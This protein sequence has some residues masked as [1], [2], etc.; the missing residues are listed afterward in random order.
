MKKPLLTQQSMLKFMKFSILQSVIALIFTSLS[1]ALDS[2]GQEVLNQ[3]V[4]ITCKE[5]KLASV[6]SIIEE[7]AKVKFVF[8]SKLIKSSRIASLNV[9]QEKLATVLSTLLSPMQ[10]GYQVNGNKIILNRQAESKSDIFAKGVAENTIIDPITGKVSSKNGEVIPGA[11]VI[12]KGTKRG[13]TTD[14]I[15]SFTINADKGET[16]QV[17]FIG[18]ETKELI[19]GTDDLQ[20]IVLSESTSTLAEVAVVGSRSSSARTNTDSPVPVDIISPKELKGF[21]QVD[22]GQILNYVAPSFSSNRQTVAD[23]T[24]HIDP[25][26][27]RGLG[28]DQVLVLVNGK[29]RHTT[30]LLNINGT[31][32]RGS[33]GT[34][35]NVIPV[36]AIERIEVLRDGAAA[37]YGSDA[38]AGVINV[39]LKKNYDGFAA[40]LTSGTNVTNMKWNTPNIGGGQEAKNLKI[41]DGEVLQF[42]LSKG[43]KIGNGGHVVVSGQ[44]NSHGTTNRSGYDNAPTIYLGSAGGFPG[45]PAGGDPATFRNKI[46]A[47]DASIVSQRNYNRRNM[48]FGNSSS[49]NLGMYVNG[50]IP[51]G[52][53]AEFYFSGGLTHR[54]GTGYGN[55]RVPVSRSQQ[56]LKSDGSLFYAD[57]FLPAIQSTIED[58][59]LQFGYKTK[60]GE[61]N[62][63]LA[64]TFGRNTFNFTVNN[65]GNA[66]LANND[67]QQTKFD[68]GTLKFDQNTT[69]LDFSRLYEKVGAIS[70]LNI[71]F[72][73][74]FRR[75]HYQIEAGETASY[76]GVVK[77][78]PTAPLSIGGAAPGT[79]VA[80]PGSQVFPGFQPSNAVNKART[81]LGLYGDFEGEIFDR[82]LL[83]LAGRY[84]NY[85]DFGSNFSGKISGRLKLIEGL[86]LRGSV[87]TGFRAPSLHQRYFSNISTQFVSGL[88][89]NTLTVNND[90]PIARKVIGVD[91]LRPETSL[92]FTTGVTARIAKT[93]TITVD[94]YQIAIKDRVVYSGAFSR[95]LLGF[96]ATDYVGVNNVNFFANAA[97]TR[98][99]GV[100]IV[101]NSKNKVANGGLNVTIAMN[102]NK[103]KVTEIN[104]TAL[105]D[106]PEKNV[107]TTNPGNWFKN[108]LF[109]RQQI[110]RIE[111]WQPNSKINLSA[112]YSVGKFDFSLRTVR[113]GQAQYVHN[114]YTEAKKPD[115]I[116]WNTSND[117]AGKA[118]PLFSYNSDGS[119]KIDQVFNPVWI[120]DLAVSYKI[121]KALN[122]TFGANNLF[123]VYPDQIF[124][125]PRN[126]NGSVDY[127]SGRDASNRGRLLFQ[128]NQGGYNGRYIFGRLNFNF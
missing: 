45:T 53:K 55:N 33:V 128:P 18:Y 117:I 30:A 100:D 89:S 76:S 29:R 106:S 91:A 1:F 57:G 83:G 71:A 16:L 125:D 35:M 79:T 63:D 6:L 51:I 112:V 67:N 62:M 77:S 121:T 5:Q 81:N 94:A 52:T 88:P 108:L 59:S 39:V 115:G 3:A 38:I 34:D 25:A 32:G 90:D 98:T 102:F 107:V 48:L 74:E 113:F 41:T 120:T 99:Q 36:A 28:P 111:V 114:A 58:Q 61:W 92:S 9:H 75:D 101:I 86:A 56:P 84:E 122:L 70:G 103:N 2:K 93:T 85:S 15:G 46:I 119:A 23:G 65:S 60:L 43:F 96:A 19:V 14:G 11:N 10:I 50:G 12:I 87:S 78:V 8:S 40:S 82:L 47:D 124:I 20:K 123:D 95:S 127:A 118:Q 4:T 54:T 42:D 27:L 69:N 7:N 104:S 80:G 64:N 109:D 49:Q 68:A 13:V 97:N 44:Y 72:G 22:L 24:D 21:S 110:S 105:I 17:S 31:V 73:T 26:S 116:Y 37:Q 126:A 66:T